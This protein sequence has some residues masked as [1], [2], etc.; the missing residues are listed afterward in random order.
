MKMLT[1]LAVLVTGVLT[2]FRFLGDPVSPALPEG[3]PAPV[4]NFS[5]NPITESGFELGRRLFYDT[6]LS[7]DNTISCASCHLQFTGFAHVDHNVS[8]GIEGRK[9]TR[10]APAL[11]NLIWQERFH[12]D[13]GVN[14]L[15]VQAINPITHPAEMDNSLEKVLGYINHSPEY[16]K[17]FYAAFGDSV[18]TS[19]TM[20]K[21]L[22]QF[23]ASLISANAKY[24][25]VMR[26]EA[27]FTSQEEN[28]LRLFRNHCASCHKE[29]LF[30]DSRFA[31]NGLPMDTAYNDV[32]RYAITH[33]GKDSLH[34]RIPT[35]RNIEVTFPYMHDGRFQ[36]LRDV[37]RHYVQLNP[38]TPYLSEELRNPIPL[39][40]EE[41]KD[42][43]AFLHTLTD[44]EFLYNPL[45]GFPK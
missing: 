26:G 24:D 45:F 42:L 40:P 38:S 44:R 35:L 15:D 32:G 12:W 34:F 10:N 18:P 30:S 4:Y 11:I 3:W 41:Q 1:L 21:A 6:G 9:G 25:R 17:M 37:V 36:R 28:G 23:T 27:Q 31:G 43:I 8:H 5:Q 16:R 39:T 22:S 29:P 2:A 33:Q 20:L 13:G 19:K 14:H 7:R